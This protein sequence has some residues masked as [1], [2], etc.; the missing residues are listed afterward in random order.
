MMK[1]AITTIEFEENVNKGDLCLFATSVHV[2]ATKYFS[3]SV[4]W[5]IYLS[6][7]KISVYV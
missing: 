3:Y 2:M 7:F 5:E 4:M 1:V 6:Y